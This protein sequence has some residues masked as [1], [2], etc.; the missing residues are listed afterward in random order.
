MGIIQQRSR[1]SQ[2][3]AVELCYLQLNQLFGVE[4]S[5]F[6]LKDG[7]VCLV[8]STTS[9]THSGQRGIEEKCSTRSLLGIQMAISCDEDMSNGLIHDLSSSGGEIERNPRTITWDLI[10]RRNQIMKEESRK[11]DE[12]EAADGV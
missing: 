4:Y 2:R 1:S 11:R 5:H 10:S 7:L 12:G 8:F 6:R 3:L 9:K